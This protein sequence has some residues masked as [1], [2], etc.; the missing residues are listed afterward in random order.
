M[1]ELFCFVILVL[2]SFV[3]SG[4]SDKISHC[5]FENKKKNTFPYSEC[6]E[7]NFS[8]R[9][10]AFV[11]VNVSQGS[12]KNREWQPSRA[13]PIS[14]SSVDSIRNWIIC[15]NLWRKC[16]DNNLYPYSSSL[17]QRIFKI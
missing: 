4:V 11:R 14:L 6:G 9:C 3:N 1:N 15:F 17:Y 2:L 7:T 5:L 13:K 8:K 16:F 12:R 10:S